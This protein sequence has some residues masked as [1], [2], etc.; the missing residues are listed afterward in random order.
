MKISEVFH[1]KFKISE[2]FPKCF[3]TISEGFP[4][5]V[6]SFRRFSENVFRFFEDHITVFCLYNKKKIARQ[7]EDVLNIFSSHVR[8]FLLMAGRFYQITPCIILYRLCLH[9]EKYN[10]TLT[11][12][13]F[14]P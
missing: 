9:Y 3:L 7:R 6:E 10:S 4:K 5:I 1:E 12:C 13:M 2:K 11:S 8:Y 14:V